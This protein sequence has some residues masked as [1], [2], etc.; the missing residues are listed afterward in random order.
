MAWGPVADAG[1]LAENAAVRELLARRLGGRLLTADR[2]LDTLER[3]LVNDVWEATVVDLDWRAVRAGLPGAAAPKFADVLRGVPDLPSG[4]EG[5]ESLRAQLAEKSPAEVT[6]VLRALIAEQVANVLRLP[7]DRLDTSR[8]LVDCGMDSLMALELGLALEKEVG[9]DMPPLSLGDRTSIDTLAALLAGRI[10]GAPQAGA[11]SDPEASVVSILF[12][13]H[14]A[15]GDEAD[16]EELA[17]TLDIG[18]ARGTRLV[19]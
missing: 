11:A 18:D 17:E 7:L 3:L 2:A 12:D 14:V 1:Y 9:I 10:A 16:M 19:R 4:I 5:T 15:P 6:A 8:S 13:Q